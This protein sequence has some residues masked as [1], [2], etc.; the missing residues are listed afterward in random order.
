M[1]SKYIAKKPRNQNGNYDPY[2]ALAST[3]VLLA[4]S[5]YFDL[6]YERVSPS[7]K[8][9][10]KELF[11]FFHS[12]YFDLLTTLD[13]EMCWKQMDKMFREGKDYKYIN[14]NKR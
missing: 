9:N 11:N 8:L 1:P 2:Q 4:I 14:Y 10:L 7:G 12:S 3:I 6:R 13:G 5:D